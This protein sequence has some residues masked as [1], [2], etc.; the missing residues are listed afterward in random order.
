MIMLGPA[1]KAEA[2]RRCWSPTCPAPRAS[3]GLVK[4]EHQPDVPRSDDVAVDQL[5]A[6]TGRKSV[7]VNDR[8]D[9][10]HIWPAISGDLLVGCVAGGG[11]VEEVEDL[12]L[13]GGQLGFE[14]LHELAV[15][16]E[17]V[18][19]ADGAEDLQDALGGGGG[20]AT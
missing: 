7:S 6:L 16:V 2:D 5:T 9:V 11:D 3:R 18:V 20:A 14:G 13:L 4:L 10:P 12:G 19:A 1:A 8:A 17:Q 15:L